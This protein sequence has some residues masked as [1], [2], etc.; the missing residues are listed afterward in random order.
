GCTGRSG[1]GAKSKCR[2]SREHL[3]RRFPDTAHHSPRHAAALHFAPSFAAPVRDMHATG[4]KPEL[5]PPLRALAFGALGVVFG[6]IG[7]SPLYT[8]QEIF[9]SDYGLNVSGASVF[10][11]LSL[12]FWSLVLVVTVKYVV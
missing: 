12:V 2:A 9:S 11:V 3:N 6:D 8:L 7:T 4:S 5:S 1:Q 10:G